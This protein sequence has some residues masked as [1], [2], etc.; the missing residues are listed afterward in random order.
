MHQEQ[1]VATPTY[2]KETDSSNLRH[3]PAIHDG[4]GTIV[5][6]LFFRDHSQ[7][8]IRFDIWELP[9]GA[10]EGAHTY[11]DD[12]ALEEIYYVLQG[13]GKLLIE[14]EEVTVTPGEAVLVPP[15]V[16]HALFNTGAEPLRLVLLWGE[17]QPASA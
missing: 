17:P 16:D 9:P 8:P 7:L 5:R 2:F 13:Q 12:D 4:D 14:G 6:K 15:G 11:A 1:P 3:Q 10:S